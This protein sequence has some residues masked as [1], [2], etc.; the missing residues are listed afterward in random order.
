M[1][2]AFA[3]PEELA[4]IDCLMKEWSSERMLR[5]PQVSAA[6]DLFVQHNAEMTTTFR[7]IPVDEGEAW[8][9]AI[10]AVRRVTG[11]SLDDSAHVVRNAVHS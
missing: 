6:R 3:T 11:L 9:K 1:S 4:R 7:P 8:R 10:R 2:D 5:V